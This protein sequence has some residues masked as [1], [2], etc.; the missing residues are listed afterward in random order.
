MSDL[1]KCTG[2]GLTGEVGAPCPT[3]GATFWMGALGGDTGATFPAHTHRE[4]PS[5]HYL[6][7]I[8]D[9]R[10]EPLLQAAAT[11]RL[12]EEQTI[13]MLAAEVRS[14]KARLAR[15]L[16]SKASAA[17]IAWQDVAVAERN[18]APVNDDLGALWD[19]AKKLEPLQ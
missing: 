6:P 17:V 13:D 8:N 1:K 4:A 18:R 10:D 16:A 5:A 2:S 11:Y 19:A 9:V 7:R 12:T 15:A 3:C 14:L